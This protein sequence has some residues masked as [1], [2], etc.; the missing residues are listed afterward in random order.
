MSA[1]TSAQSI[2]D[3]K[4]AADYS[5]LGGLMLAVLV[6]GLVIPFAAILLTRVTRLRS[7]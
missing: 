7:A 6:L 1:E 3:V 5:Q 4:V 2:A